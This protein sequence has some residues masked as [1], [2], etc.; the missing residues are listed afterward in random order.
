MERS[1][2]TVSAVTSGSGNGV[3]FVMHFLTVVVLGVFLS[4]SSLS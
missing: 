2:H 1:L 4:N 3:I